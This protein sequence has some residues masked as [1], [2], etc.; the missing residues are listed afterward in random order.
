M[1]GQFCVF[2]TA[3]E[4]KVFITHH[5]SLYTLATRKH[6]ILSVMPKLSTALTMVFSIFWILT[7]LQY[8]DEVDWFS[9]TQR[10]CLCEVDELHTFRNGEDEF[11]F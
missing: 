4:V 1:P 7:E 2:S 8:L 10:K 11:Y 5:I 6:K 3:S 9:E